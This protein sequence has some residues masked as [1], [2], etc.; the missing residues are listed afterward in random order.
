MTKIRKARIFAAIIHEPK[1]R[2]RAAAD[3]QSR[4]R[5][6]AAAL[7]GWREECNCELRA[8]DLRPLAGFPVVQMKKPGLLTETG[9]LFQ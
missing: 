4:Q 7:S 8:A 3:F 1:S 2:L 5:W 6:N 9:L